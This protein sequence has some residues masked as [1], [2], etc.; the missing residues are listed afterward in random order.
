MNS[1]VN[2]VLVQGAWADGSDEPGV[3]SRLITVGRNSTLA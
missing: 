3:E 1:G 2:V